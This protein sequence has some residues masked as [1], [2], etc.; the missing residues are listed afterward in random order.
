MKVG[1]LTKQEW[2]RKYPGK[3]SCEKFK[4]VQ[5]VQRQYNRFLYNWVFVR[6]QRDDFDAVVKN[7]Y[8][9]IMAVS[10]SQVGSF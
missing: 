3:C 5:P 2:N 4:C 9:T 6:G 1:Y 8:C 10:S 7:C